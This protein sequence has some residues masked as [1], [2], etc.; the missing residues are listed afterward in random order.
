M[1]KEVIKKIIYLVIA[2]ILM[3]SGIILGNNFTIIMGVLVIIFI[4]SEDN[5]IRKIEID[6]LEERIQRLEN[7]N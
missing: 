2:G 3:A 7:K 6:D 4:L 1:K 5:E